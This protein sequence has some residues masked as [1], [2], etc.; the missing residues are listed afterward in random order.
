MDWKNKIVFL[1]LCKKPLEP[2]YKNYVFYKIS[3]PKGKDFSFKID[4]FMAIYIPKLNTTFKDVSLFLYWFQIFKDQCGSV[5]S[6]SVAI[7]V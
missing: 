1:R 6:I 3:L 4:G 7:L 2:S 5:P